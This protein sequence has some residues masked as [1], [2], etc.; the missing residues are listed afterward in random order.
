MSIAPEDL[1]RPLRTARLLRGVRRALVAEGWSCLPEAP[2]ANG[3]RADLLCLDPAGGIMIIEIKSG[4]ADY[5]A[6]AKWPD[7]R[8][9]CDRFAFAVD[10]DFPDHLLPQ[11]VGLLRGD[12]YGGAWLRLPPEHK[13][14][15]ARRKAVTLLA[16][17]LAAQRLFWRDDPEAGLG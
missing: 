2:L 3:R 14:A 11:D 5:M 4:R 16:M 9:F 7:Y 12:D 13:L 6:D 1:T 17:R 8:D 15:P 10:D